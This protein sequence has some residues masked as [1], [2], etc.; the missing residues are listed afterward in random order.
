MNTDPEGQ[1]LLKAINFKGMQP[2]QDKDWDDV[3][4]L[5][6]QMLDQLIKQ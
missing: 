3:R 6:L 5:G 4:N 1:A 2:A